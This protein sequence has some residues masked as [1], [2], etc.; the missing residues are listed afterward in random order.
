MEN[1]DPAITK[2][3]YVR[4]LETDIKFLKSHLEDMIEKK[5]QADIKIESLERDLKNV[6]QKVTKELENKYKQ[7]L[8]EKKFLID[9]LKRENQAISLVSKGGVDAVKKYLEPERRLSTKSP[10]V[11]FA[12]TCLNL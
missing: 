5:S 1:L 12:I 7:E 9:S 3:Q 11:K 2:D 6:T 8:K 10:H 4:Q